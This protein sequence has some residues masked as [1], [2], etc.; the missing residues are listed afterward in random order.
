M[1]NPKDI[2]I[3]LDNDEVKVE[4]SSTST[5][6]LDVYWYRRQ[7]RTDEELIQKAWKEYN[8]WYEE[9]R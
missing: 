4:L 2:V 6:C 9:N 3:N 7:G 8:A 1:E 5:S